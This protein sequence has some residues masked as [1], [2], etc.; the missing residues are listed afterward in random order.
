MQSYSVRKFLESHVSGE[1]H[2]RTPTGQS[3]S[4]LNYMNSLNKIVENEDTDIAKVIGETMKYNSASVQAIATNVGLQSKYGS[5]MAGVETLENQLQQYQ[6]KR[7]YESVLD[8]VLDE[9]D[10]STASNKKFE[11]QTA[12]ARLGLKFNP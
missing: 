9:A 8:D 6:A 2:R 4:T 1:S 7:V 10:K 11:V 3:L 5:G 12:K